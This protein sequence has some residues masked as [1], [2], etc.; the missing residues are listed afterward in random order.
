M[1][2]VQTKP[3]NIIVEEGRRLLYILLEKGELRKLT[4][5]QIADKVEKYSEKK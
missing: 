5:E 3:K 2:L 4:P 1:I